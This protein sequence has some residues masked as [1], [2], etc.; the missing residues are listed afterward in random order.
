MGRKLNLILVQKTLR[1]RGFK[2]FTPREFAQIFTTSKIS[3]QK[4]LERYTKK[5]VFLRA[6][7][8]LYIFEFEPAEEFLF[9]NKI[10]SPSYISLESALSLYHLIPE[11]VYAVTSITTKPTREFSIGE[12]LFEYRK[13][14]LK[15]FTGYIPQKI[16][17]EISLVATPEKALVDYLYFVSLGKKS[18]NERLD[19]REVDFTQ[20]KRYARLFENK[21]L[22]RIINDF[23]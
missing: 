22:E 15:A 16:G 5:G 20:V 6:K 1:E 12:R 10:Y 9:A 4:F 2:I 7:K 17:G 8:G 14:K 21:K 19:L 11:T 3:A 13:I 18:L 23:A